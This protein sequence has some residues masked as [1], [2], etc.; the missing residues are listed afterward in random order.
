MGLPTY[1][2]MESVRIRTKKEA[3][4]YKGKI[5]YYLRNIDVDS[6]GRGYYFVR[7]LNIDR[8][9]CGLFLEKS[10]NNI[11]YRDIIKL[12]VKE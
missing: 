2:E 4:K 8:V 12:K 3:E 11:Y 7:C 5:I 1:E 6:S 9:E 10:G